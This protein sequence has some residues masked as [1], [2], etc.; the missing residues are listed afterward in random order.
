MSNLPRLPPLA[1]LFLTHFHDLKGQEVSYYVS[2]DGEFTNAK[3]HAD[4]FDICL[5]MPI[6]PVQFILT[7]ADSI[8]PGRIEHTS[9]PSGLH[10]RDQDL[11]TFT[12]C[13]LPGAGLF[14]SR[15][16]ESGRGRRMGT[17]G[18]VLGEQ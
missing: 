7:D 1:A 17:L 8:P 14:R 11:I 2:L 12:H 10:Q 16:Q 5:L 9:L 4:G 18:V 6:S 3:D 13:G 15:A